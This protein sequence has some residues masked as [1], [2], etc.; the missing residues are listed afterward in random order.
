MFWEILPGKLWQGNLFSPT[1]MRAECVV[2]C[3]RIGLSS[4]LVDVLHGFPLHVLFP[5]EDAD[6]LPDKATLL[7][8]AKLVVDEL[9]SSK[10]VLVHC[11]AG[12]NRSGLVIAKVLCLQGYTG[13]LAMIQRAHP[14]ALA[15]PVFAEYV[16]GMG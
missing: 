16:S 14:E 5:F 11:N 13:I 7:A 1:E 2:T 4:V 6:H 15:N 3:T 12:Q 8:V 10:T 9:Q